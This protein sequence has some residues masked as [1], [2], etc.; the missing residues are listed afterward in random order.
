VRD[1]QAALRLRIRDIAEA[2]VGWGYRRIQV[3]L[4]REGW[5]V[6][7]KRVLR[8]YREESLTIRRKAP[9][10][11]VAAKKRTEKTVPRT[12]NESWSMGFMADQLF[13]GRRIRLL[14]LVDNFSRESL[15]IEVGQRFTGAAVAGVLEQI[16]EQR[17]HP[18]EIRVDNGPEF[19]SKELDLWAYGRNVKLDFSRPG[20][21]TDNAFIESFNG[22]LRKECLT[23]ISHVKRR[24]ARPDSC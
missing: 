20:K 4:Q 6:N 13:D 19:I 5:L 21:P 24:T 12:P 3:M 17:G 16:T 18:T 10:R 14:T 8:L 23:L 11:R 7:H 15:A 2:R 22:Q 9:R 1:G